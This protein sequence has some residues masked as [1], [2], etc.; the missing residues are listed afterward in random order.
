MHM[1]N[2]ILEKNRFFGFSF[3]HVIFLLHWSSDSFLH[4]IFEMM[5]YFVTWP[6]YNDYFLFVYINI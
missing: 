3:G 4:V 6:R 1:V 2:G 5:P